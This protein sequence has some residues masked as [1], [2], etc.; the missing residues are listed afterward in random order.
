MTDEAGGMSCLA[1]L[2]AVSYVEPKVLERYIASTFFGMSDL[3][4]GRLCLT[5][6][7]ETVMLCCKI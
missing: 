2:G 7:M 3:D 5:G 4:S 1:V 6:R